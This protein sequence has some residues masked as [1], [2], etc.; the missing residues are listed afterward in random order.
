MTGTENV[1]FYSALLGRDL[2]V[3]ENR[4]SA[5]GEWAG[6]TD[7]MDLPLRTFSSGMVARLAFAVATDQS[8]DVLLIDEVLSVGDVEFQ[9]KSAERMK[10]LIS[11][12]AAVVLVSHDLTAVRRLATKAIW[13][14]SGRVM[15][16]GDVEEVTSEYELSFQS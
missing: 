1:R 3:V 10:Q 5:I 15:K 13:I 9:T 12:G 6:V 8:A 7:H 2:K 4:I 14:E 16:Y 11:G